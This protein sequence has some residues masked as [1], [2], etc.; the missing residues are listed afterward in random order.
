MRQLLASILLMPLFLVA[1]VAVNDNCQDA[2]EI[3]IPSNGFLLDTIKS[4]PCDVSDAGREIGEMC[5]KELEDAG[6]C[7]KTVW[8][9]FYIPTTRSL[10]IRLMQNDSAIPQIFS[11]FNVYKVKDCNFYSSDLSKQLQPVSNFGT[12]GNNCLSQGWYLV[13]VGCKKKAKGEL[14]L[15]LI[16]SEPLSDSYDQVAQMFDVSTKSWNASYSQFLNVTCASVER[17]E[18]LSINDS[19]FSKS[20]W[21]SLNLFSNYNDQLLDVFAP[22]EFLF[23]LFLNDANNDSGA[24]S[25]P[26]LNGKYFRNI[27]SEVCRNTNN[28]KVCI[29]FVLKTTTTYVYLSVVQT[30]IPVDPWNNPVQAESIVLEPNKAVSRNHSFGCDAE[31]KTQICKNIVPQTYIKTYTN[32]F[33]PYLKYTDTFRYAGYKVLD[34]SSDGVLEVVI[35]DILYDP[36]GFMLLQGD[37]S[38]NCQLVP[39]KDSVLWGYSK[40]R[41]CVSKGIYTLVVMD[42]MIRNRSYP[43][44][45][46]LLSAS[47]PTRFGYLKSSEPLGVYQQLKVVGDTVVFREIDTVLTVGTQKFKGRFV[48]R[49]IYL[50]EDTDLKISSVLNGYLLVLSGRE[51]DG[52]LNSVPGVNYSKL[53]YTA[54]LNEQESPQFKRCFYLNKGYYTLV[55]YLPYNDFVLLNAL[56]C[57][58][59]LNA[60]IIEPNQVCQITNTEPIR[61]V[62]LNGM[63]NVL[64][65]QFY[66]KDSLNYSYSLLSCNS[67][68]SYTKSKPLLSYIRKAGTDD[69]TLYSYYVFKVQDNVSIRIN[70]SRYELYR[71]DAS[72]DE[73]VV[74]DTSNV[75]SPCSAGNIICN[76]SKGE[77]TLV[78]IDQNSAYNYSIVFSK[79]RKTVNDYIVTAVDLG[80]AGAKKT[81]KG[82]YIS[83]HTG[84]LVNDLRYLYAYNAYDLRKVPIKWKDSSDYRRNNYNNRNIWYTFT[85]SGSSEVDLEIENTNF[86]YSLQCLVYRYKGPYNASFSD[87]VKNGLDSSW[88]NFELVHIANQYRSSGK[89]K[90]RND[91]C[92]NSRYFVVIDRMPTYSFLEGPGA[93]FFKVSVAATPLNLSFKGDQCSNPESLTIQS[94]G[95]YKMNAD[96]TCH[97]YGGSPFEE[98]DQEGVKSTWYQINVSDIDRFELGIRCSSSKGLIRFVLYGGYCGAMTPVAKGEDRFA[99]FSISCMKKGVYYLQAISKSS[100]QENIEFEVTVKEDPSSRCAPYDFRHPIAGFSIQGGCQKADTVKLLNRSSSGSDMRFRWYLNGV[101][102]STDR[103][104]SFDRNSS[105]IGPSNQIVLIAENIQFGYND[106]FESE[107]R[108]DVQL[109]DFSIHVNNGIDCSD[110]FNAIV[111]TNY[112]YKVNYTWTNQWGQVLSERERWQGVASGRLYVRGISDNCEF[113]DEI[114]LSYK[115]SLGLFKDTIVCQSEKFQIVNTSEVNWFVINDNTS[116]FIKPGEHK[117][118]EEDGRLVVSSFDG[119][120]QYRDTFNVW[121]LDLPEKILSQSDVFACGKDT[122]QLRYSKYPFT[123][124]LWDNGDRSATRVVTKEGL[125]QVKLKVGICSDIDHTFNVVKS[126]DQFRF[127]KDT[128]VCRYDEF[129]LLSP[130][131]GSEVLERFPDKT[132]VR[133]N[134]PFEYSLKIRAGTCLLEDK[135]MVSLVNPGV[136]NQDTFLCDQM[137]SMVLELDP[138]MGEDYNWY[139]LGLLQRVIKVQK[140]GV[141]PVIY[142][143]ALTTC[144]DTLVY[145]VRNACEFAVYIPDGFSPNG[146]NVNDEFMPVVAGA[147]NGF[148]YKIF[149]R[150]GEM[151]YSGNQSQIWDGKS[152]GERV[153]QGV[154]SYLVTVFDAQGRAFVFKGTLV[155]LR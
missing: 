124:V 155:V 148:E 73:A 149:N 74:K 20:I 152:G 128:Q 98:V 54:T 142:T 55:S 83:C 75:V 146:D 43:I 112:P 59:L 58:Q 2:I 93:N 49:E 118:V 88:N 79:Q 123:S 145:N 26:F 114:L 36:M 52:S 81:S 91:G 56:P 1:Q 25:K 63:N 22:D 51:S 57:E 110:S 61:A 8:Y 80:E 41:A 24:S 35:K 137:K 87:L 140:Y 18:A 15:Q 154:Y 143:S 139:T 113:E 102:F 16:L 28:K 95:T 134:A 13:Q 129:E 39:V 69:Y 72:L 48:F 127:L 107:Y 6:N 78:M 89:I 71:G 42:K 27:I 67:C 92:K 47:Y 9:K 85:A 97:G 135:A 33:Y 23:R 45:F 29:Q 31:L 76:L 50:P 116:Y 64:S 44:D 120:C 68:G 151:I 103:E 121:H 4:A 153:P 30:N 109:Y 119:Q 125:Y 99:F 19:D 82:E 60:V 147:N 65:N 70:S 130:V 150:W 84:S 133:A 126:V 10:A 11:G 40:F 5:S 62:R 17:K 53:V 131:P 38:S 7:D 101:L 86:S 117:L 115:N 21:V 32:T 96:N 108:K 66:A 105:N 144:R 90:F 122:V 77:Y 14:W 34:V 141:Y 104:V 132:V 111:N 46:T 106:T 37:I 138:G 100:I 12:S 3:V 136:V 94:E